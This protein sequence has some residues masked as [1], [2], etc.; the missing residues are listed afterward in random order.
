MARRLASALAAVPARLRRH[1]TYSSV[2]S[3]VAVFIALGGI[4]YAAIKLP[5]NSVGT[6]Q[7]R[8]KAVTLKKISPKAQKRLRSGKTG[9]RGLQGPQGPQGP[10]GLQGP[11]GAPGADGASGAA[12]LTGL[13]TGVP[14]TTS[15]SILR[16]VPV[17]GQGDASVSNALADIASLSPART[18]VAR[19]ISVRVENDLP[20]GGSTTVALLV[21][22][23]LSEGGPLPT[24][25]NCS[26]VGTAGSSDRT[27]S[28]PGPI[29]IPA[30]SFM[31]IRVTNS[32]GATTSDPATAYWGITIEP[33]NG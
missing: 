13:A 27:C 22:S 23:A 12:L 33:A 24:Q 28:A 18:L 16:R 8:A 5:P 32:A 10:D 7:I 19:D 1:V 17:M 30:D 20:V 31:W 4:S 6:K 9:A 25:L 26:V 29:T 15:G 14:S 21:N 3:T 11:A 2:M